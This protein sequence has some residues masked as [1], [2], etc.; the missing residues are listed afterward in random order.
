MNAAQEM[1]ELMDVEIDESDSIS[2]DDIKN[3]NKVS[4][5]L[6]DCLGESASHASIGTLIENQKRHYSKRKINISRGPGIYFVGRVP[7][8]EI[9][10]K[11]K[12]CY[13]NR[14]SEISWYDNQWNEV[15]Q[16][17]E[18]SDFILYIGKASSLRKRIAAYMN[19]IDQVLDS[20]KE[21]KAAHRGG[22]AVC[23]FKEVND[24]DFY[25][26]SFDD[27]NIKMDSE[28]VEEIFIQKY[29]NRKGSYPFANWRL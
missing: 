25:W 2:K 27:L 16:K 20:K 9:T 4:Q 11:T 28:K 29:C 12:G 14:S 19:F 21:I 18:N 17:K 5:K 1:I 26:V 6:K 3:F 7:G 24:L 15:K 10:L 13:A 22:R 8:K 23:L